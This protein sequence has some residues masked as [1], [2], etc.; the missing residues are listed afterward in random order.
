MRNLRIA[1]AL[2]LMIGS[3]RPNILIPIT[4]GSISRVLNDEVR[5]D[6]DEAV[7]HVV[8]EQNLSADDLSRLVEK[9]NTLSHQVKR[10]WSGEDYPRLARISTFREA[11]ERF[12]AIENEINAA[13]KYLRHGFSGALG[14]RLPSTYPGLQDPC[15]I[16]PDMPHP[17]PTQPCSCHPEPGGPGGPT[18]APTNRYIWEFG[19]PLHCHDPYED[20][21]GDDLYA[22]YAYGDGFGNTKLDLIPETDGTDDLDNGENGVW[23]FPQRLIYNDLRPDGYLHIEIDIWEKD[24]TAEFFQGL[25]DFLSAIAGPLGAAIGGAAGGAIG[26]LVGQALD[27]ARSQI[28]DNDD[29]NYLG[30]IVFDYPEGATN[31]SSILLA[32]GGGQT[33][34]TTFDWFSTIEEGVHYQ[35]SYT[36]RDLGP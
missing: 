13:R 25:L 24:Y 1:K 10:R 16:D 17:C 12:L 34:S 29:D 9:Y 22:V 6:L 32:A 26:T 5:G 20:T 21:L 30:K 31:L 7:R 2:T 23:A 3:R 28:T 18:P 4:Y 36:V 11:A 35:F 14:P 8:Q 15:P 19:P 33:F 27:A